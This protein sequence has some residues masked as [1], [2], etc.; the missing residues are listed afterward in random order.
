MC[1]K[2]IQIDTDNLQGDVEHC[3]EKLFCACMYCR[4]ALSYSDRAIEAY[5]V[6]VALLESELGLLLANCRAA[7]IGN[8]NNTKGE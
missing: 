3:T 1:L 5:D 4:I 8:Q 7:G 2:V 6:L